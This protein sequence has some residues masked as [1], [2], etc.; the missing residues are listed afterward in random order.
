MGIYDVRGRR[1]SEMTINLADGR[2]ERH[3]NGLDD[4][5]GSVP[6]G[7]YFLRLEGVPGVPA[8]KFVLLK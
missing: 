6:S 3:W 2:G 7:V 4:S 1:I 8:R 5:G